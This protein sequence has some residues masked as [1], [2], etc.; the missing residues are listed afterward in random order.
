MKGAHQNVNEHLRESCADGPI[1]YRDYIQLAL[2]AEGCGY[3]TRVAERVGRS[4]AHDFYTAESLGKVFAQ[5]VSTAAEDLLGSEL[6]SAKHLRRNRRRTRRALLDTLEH[7]T[8]AEGKV[9]RQGQPIAVVRP[10]RPLRQRV[11]R[12]PALPPLDFQDQPGGN[13]ES[14]RIRLQPREILLNG[15]S[16]PV[17]AKAHQLPATGT[18]GLRTRLATGG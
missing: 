1:S 8:F 13:V 5:L 14:T 2:Y 17:A 18:R 4:S 9:I 12:R 7:T 15:L 3:Y 10:G 6:S 16:E 11:A